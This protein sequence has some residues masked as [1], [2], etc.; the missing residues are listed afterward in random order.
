MIYPGPIPWHIVY[1]GDNISTLLSR[2]YAVRYIP[3]RAAIGEST[4]NTTLFRV[5]GGGEKLYL[6][7]KQAI[8]RKESL[9][10]NDVVRVKVALRLPLMNNHADRR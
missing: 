1:V 5:K 3:V 6:M 4:W 10:V 9:M 8:A 7:I 2:R